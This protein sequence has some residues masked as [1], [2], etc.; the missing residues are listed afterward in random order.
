[1]SRSRQSPSPSGLALLFG[2]KKPA[3]IKMNPKDK[4]EE[5]VEGGRENLFKISSPAH[6]GQ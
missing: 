3:S 4:A 6:C 1:M 2:N 5:A